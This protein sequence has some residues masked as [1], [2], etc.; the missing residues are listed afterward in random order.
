MRQIRKR[1]TSLDV[2]EKPAPPVMKILARTNEPGLGA[3]Y[4]W[5]EDAG[6]GEEEEPGE[7][8]EEEAMAEE[9][10]AAVEA[11]GAAGADGAFDTFAEEE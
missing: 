2:L 10:D 11:G 7:E 8:E 4:A 1:S 3:A 6:G 9:E 5:D